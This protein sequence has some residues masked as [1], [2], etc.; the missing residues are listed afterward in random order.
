MGFEVGGSPGGADAGR[1]RGEAFQGLLIGLPGFR[2]TSGVD[3]QIP[4]AG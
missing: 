3:Q 1:E 2:G 4:A